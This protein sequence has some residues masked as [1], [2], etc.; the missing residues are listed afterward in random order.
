MKL[1][2]ETNHDYTEV[3]NL[4]TVQQNLT[5]FEVELVDPV[6]EFNKL[7]GYKIE[8][9]EAGVYH[10]KFD[11][12]KY[13]A[14]IEAQKKEQ[15][16]K[17]GEAL[18]EELKEQAILESASDKNAYVMRYMYDEWMPDT[19][20]RVDDR[21][22]YKDNLY[23]CKQNHTSQAEHTPDL[24]P[25]LWDLINPDDTKGTKENPIEVPEPFSSMIYIKGKYYLEDGK[26]YLMN[27]EGMSD[28]EE[29]SLTFKPSALINVYFALVEE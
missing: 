7:K 27:R 24:V 23:K 25:A 13:N 15:A 28:G 22:F 20:Y 18:M 26:I 11:Q 4:S 17:D 1:Y 16:I 14:F 3:I 10:L 6:F 21:E 12:E 5:Y 8:L 9:V 29:I 2:V 19:D